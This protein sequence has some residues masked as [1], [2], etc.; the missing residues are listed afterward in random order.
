MIRK[1]CVVT[2][3]RADFG[4]LYWLMKEIQKDENLEL[5]IIVTGMHLSNEFGLTYKEIEKEFIIQ[6]KIEIIMSSDTSI[7]VSKSLGLGI[8]SFSESFEELKPDIIVV[9]GDRYEILS[10][11]S[12]GMIAKIPIAHIHGGEA[13][14]SLIDESIRHSISKMSH[15]HFTAT[16]Q[17][18]KRVIQLGEMPQKV[19]NVGGLGIENINK[20][21]LLKK[22]VFEKSINFKLNVKNLLVAYH[23]ITLEHNKTEKE[24]MTLLEIINELEDTNIIFTKSNSDVEGRKINKL[25]DQYVYENPKNSISI[26]S[27][28][29]IRYLSAL[30]YVDA[31]VG[32]SSSGLLEAPSL[33]I[34]TIN[35]GGRQDGRI[36]ASSVIDC[37][38]NK[39][40]LIKAFKK[41]YSSEFQSALK[42]VDNPYGNENASYKIVKILKTIKLENILKKSFYDI[43]YEL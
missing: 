10:A 41:L 40:N 15:I 13:T 5:L 3:T 37:L 35:I 38:P 9:L 23:P 20:L 18:R 43:E 27:L 12:A 32:N 7:G 2:G 36:K 34:G 1:V 4:L 26:T 30:K 22:N 29:Q 19:F 6:K 39:Q 31:I 14:Y 25:I 21:K 24:F 28:G 8:I 33:K 16:D 42:S 11:V 17:Y